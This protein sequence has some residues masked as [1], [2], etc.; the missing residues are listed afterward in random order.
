MRR[1][2]S[3]I[4]LL[5]AAIVVAP[6]PATAGGFT[7]IVSKTG[8]PNGFDVV[9][10]S[11]PQGLPATIAPTTA[12]GHVFGAG[13]PPT[14]T[15]SLSVLPAVQKLPGLRLTFGGSLVATT[16]KVS[17]RNL[18]VLNITSIIRVTAGSDDWE[19][20]GT[21]VNFAP[22]YATH[23]VL[24]MN[25]TWYNITD[26]TTEGPGSIA[27]FFAAHT[28]SA[29]GATISMLSGDCAH[30]TAY[31]VWFD[32][33]DYAEQGF[34][35]RYDFESPTGGLSIAVNHQTIASGDP[36]RVSTV[37]KDG[38]VRWP[39]AKVT[40]WAKPNG[41]DHFV[42]VR[43]VDAT[44]AKGGASVTLHPMTTTTYQWRHAKDLYVQATRSPTKVVHV[45][46]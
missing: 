5:A 42:K 31:R 36:V 3:V 10:M 37:L 12:Y 41:A 1:I 19:L 6:S 39:A 44:N 28:Q 9:R 46:H 22:N 27:Q 14:G 45:T 13:F 24:G 25:Y 29:P 11:C 8:L 20:R 7:R 2:A 32:H 18:E 17:V 15:G 35:Y 38:G 34:A 43:T 30:V 16:L 26:A 33:V 4:V 40:L 23:D 21:D